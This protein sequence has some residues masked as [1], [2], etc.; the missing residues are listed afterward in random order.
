MLLTLSILM[1]IAAVALWF[2]IAFSKGW[3]Q[4]VREFAA[5]EFLMERDIDDWPHM[6]FGT[7]SEIERLV[8]LIKQGKVLHIALH[9]FLENRPR[10]RREIMRQQAIL[11]PQS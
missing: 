5:V 2:T 6:P 1:P 11:P 3:N 9:C 7:L 10:L 8:G 4:G